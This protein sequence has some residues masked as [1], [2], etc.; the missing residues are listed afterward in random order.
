MEAI[1]NLVGRSASTIL[2]DDVKKV[3]VASS[4]HLDRLR[5]YTTDAELEGRYALYAS[6]AIFLALVPP[7]TVSSV[8]LSTRYETLKASPNPSTDEVKELLRDL[9]KFRDA[10]SLRKVDI[11]PRL[12]TLVNVFP[13]LPGRS[14]K[15][16]IGLMGVFPRSHD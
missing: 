7:L 11:P 2:E 14:H 13:F 3:L 12:K 4:G 9:E 15:S 16:E 6:R 10:V 8:R 1:R 5:E